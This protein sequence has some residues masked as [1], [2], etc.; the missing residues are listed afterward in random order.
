MCENNLARKRKNKFQEVK[1]KK[2]KA[3]AGT[4]RN[5]PL[6]FYFSFS[7]YVYFDAFCVS[8]SLNTQKEQQQ[9]TNEFCAHVLYM[10]KSFFFSSTAF[11]TGLKSLVCSP[12]SVLWKASRG[13]CM[14]RCEAQQ[15]PTSCSKYI[16]IRFSRGNARSFAW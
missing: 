9:Q 3:E 11:D 1:K 14:D 10:I 5:H 12:L 13:G 15:R 7:F 16:N 4:E 6:I 2:K 8:L